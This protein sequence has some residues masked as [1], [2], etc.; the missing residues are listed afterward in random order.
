M[1]SAIYSES[2]Y[3][4]E[5]V[6]GKYLKNGW[7]DQHGDFSV[8]FVI[9]KLTTSEWMKLSG[10]MTGGYRDICIKVTPQSIWIHCSGIFYKKHKWTRYLSWSPSILE[11]YW[12]NT[13]S[14]YFNNDVYS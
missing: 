12:D 2:K 6:S 4:V 10:H 7:S 5:S 14:L 8:E 11:R 3:S 13:N 1:M 9:E